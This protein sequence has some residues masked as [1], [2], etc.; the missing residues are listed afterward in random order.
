[1]QSPFRRACLRRRRQLGPRQIDFQ[2]L[3]GHGEPA[4]LVAIEQMMPAGE[5]EVFHGLLLPDVSRNGSRALRSPLPA[6][7]RSAPEGRLVRGARILEAPF[8]ARSP[9]PPPR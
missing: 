2:E 4:A 8:R 6:G 5:P 1:M 9:S 7:E 3:V